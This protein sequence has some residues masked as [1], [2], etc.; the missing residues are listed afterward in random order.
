MLSP[1]NVHSLHSQST[2]CNCICA[3]ANYQSATNN[4]VLYGLL[5]QSY[6]P[7]QMPSNFFNCQLKNPLKK[8]HFKIFRLQNGV[9]KQ[10]CRMATFYTSS[11]GLS[12]TIII[13]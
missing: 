9:E 4:L 5:F 2:L 11:V 12:M 1:T 10:I 7:C 8:A 3:S 6:D 13:I